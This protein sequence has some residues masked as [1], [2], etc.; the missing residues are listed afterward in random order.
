MLD[1]NNQHG[2]QLYAAYFSFSF[3]NIS[4][5]FIFKGR[6]NELCRMKY[7]KK[8]WWNGSWWNGSMFLTFFLWL[9]LHERFPK[10]LIIQGSY[11][12]PV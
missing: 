8:K 3:V 4:V 11:T 5:C 12:F 2:N 9:F 1:R 10:K 7:F 6:R